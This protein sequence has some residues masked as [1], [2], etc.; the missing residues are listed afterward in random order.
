MKRLLL[1]GMFLAG[2][3]PFFAAGDDDAL[4]RAAWEA[5]GSPAGFC[6]HLG[7]GRADTPGLTAALTA[8]SGMPVQGL[9]L[10]AAAFDRARKAILDRGLAGRAMAE[11]LSGKSLPHA[12]GMARM[13]VVEDA[14][15]LAA[16]GLAR[17]EWLRVL[18]PGGVL[19]TRENGKWVATVKPRPREMD[20][21]THPH[22]APDG[23]L[24]SADKTISFPIGL[25]W[26]DSVPFDRGGF[27]E[28]ASCRAVVLAG[29]RCFTINTD[30][31]N[32][33]GRALLR[34][35]DAYSGFPLWSIDC[36]GTYSKVQL[37]WRNTW[38]LAANDRRVCAGRSNDVI[39]VDAATGKIE[40]TCP[41]KYQPHRLLLVGDTVI[42]A[43]W[44]KRDQSNPKDN[45]ESDQIRAVW[46]P[47][48]EGT[49]DAFDVA[50]GRPKWSLPLCALT[51]VSADGIVYALTHKGNPPTARD[52]VAVDLATGKEKWRLPHTA[53]GDEPDTCLNFA[54]P[55]CVVVSRTKG[56]GGK[57]GVTVLAAADGKV[58]YNLTNTTARAI[59]GN[60]LWCTQTRYNLKTGE[61]IPGPGIG[62][63]YAGG[64]VVGGCVPPVVV[65]GNLITGSR[66]GGYSL[67]AEDPTKPAKALTYKGARGACLQGMVPANGMFYTAQNNCGCFGTQIGGFL[68]IG[69][70][71]EPPTAEEFQAPRPVE[72][73]P[74]FGATGPA[75]AADEWP[76]YRQNAERSGGVATALPETLKQL[77]K[78]SCVKPAEG[79]FA[80]SWN[81][82]I[83]SAQ[84]LTAPIVAAG[85]LYIAG[86]NSGELMALDPVTGAK[87][88]TVLLPSRIDS[89][90]TYHN[91]LLLVGCHDGW[92]YALRAKDGALVYRLRLAPR[93]RRLVDHGIV[94]SVW[95]AVGAVLVHDGLAYAAAGRSSTTDGGMV[96]AAFK[97]ESGELV[98]TKHFGEKTGFFVETPSVQG[99][100][101]V[102]HWMRLDLKTG[103][104]LAPAQR[105]YSNGSMIDGSW[106]AGF[107]RRSGGGLSLGRVNG[108]MLAWNS[109][110]VAAPGWAVAREKANVPKPAPNAGVKHPDPFKAGEHAWRG[111][112]EPHIE[113]A[114]IHAM[115]LAGNTALYAGDINNGWRNGAYDGSRLWI[116]NTADGKS[117]QKEID[118]G[119][120]PCYDSLAIASGRVYLA[121]QD[122]TLMCLGAG[123]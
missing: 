69:P 16:A 51:I 95:P 55:G 112:L 35:R 62:G 36:Q 85:T 7:C 79:M 12:T 41:V 96:L 108:S 90:P 122:G 91:G 21:W 73:G 98:W 115:A 37:D 2:L 113:W 11:C 107:G 42:A 111:E 78:V 92:V 39:I 47:G 15:T 32:S 60:E 57:R 13:V 33:Q 17:E 64:N 27:G 105:F 86:L 114:R 100:E 26:I 119:T 4:A 117:R 49:L 9:A 28:C 19:C 31:L 102:W 75:A 118:L 23:N 6:L 93:E 40:F 38:P 67:L 99:N 59:V 44:E 110:L 121:L 66:S 101:L 46:W 76:M 1:S 77:W 18:A 89:A 20:E 58:L 10:D 80:D 30:D 106:A 74:A 14:A 5:A 22:H 52:L 104:E 72:K 63:T 70:A 83:G 50:S 120:R 48:G 3:V 71:D 45:F 97:P 123:N 61:K 29:G 43:S 24:V 65:G 84:P 68:G 87:S 109:Q 82:R 8:C 116:K 88:W 53:F 56:G 25:R 34:A 103:A 94:E 81:A 54:A